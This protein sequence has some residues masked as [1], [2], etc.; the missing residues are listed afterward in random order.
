MVHP[1]RFVMGKPAEVWCNE[2]YEPNSANTFIPVINIAKRVIFSI[3]EVNGE[4]V[5]VIIPLIE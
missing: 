1:M 3:D 2:L 4:N 5:L